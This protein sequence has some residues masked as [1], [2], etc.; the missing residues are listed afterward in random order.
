MASMK[1]AQDF[2]KYKGL[3]V[4]INIMDIEIM[5]QVLDYLVELHNENP[6]LGIPQKMAEMR[7]NAAK[8]MLYYLS[9]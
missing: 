1:G 7:D 2:P 4:T 6:H 3:T 9:D 5:E 8:K